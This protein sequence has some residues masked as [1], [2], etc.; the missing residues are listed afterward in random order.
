MIELSV[1][2]PT[3][4]DW[5]RLQLCLAPLMES[6]STVAGREIIVVDNAPLHDPPAVITG[7]KGV[8]IIHEPRP[9]SYSARNS[10]ARVATGRYLA[11]T[12]SDCIPASDWMEQGIAYFQK[13]GADLLGGRVNL[14]R[15]NGGKEWAYIYEQ[16]MAFRQAVNVPR[17][18]SVTANLMV[19]KDV[20]DRLG[21]FDEEM[22]SGGDFEFCQRA[23]ENGYTLVYADSVMVK[24]P[25]RRDLRSIFKKQKRFAAW[26]FLNVKSRYGHSG[27]RII[28]SHLYNGIRGIF[29]RSSVPK[30]LGDKFLVFCISTGLYFYTFWL[31]SLI[32]LRLLDA[33]KIRE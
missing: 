31:Q 15:E 10:G 14:F 32:Q 7:M 13:T 12:D 18:H 17:G 19:R 1:V 30:S 29:R 27:F 23:V 20:F 8:T 4:N 28:G 33:K 21:G 6:N 2:I 5:E 11:F 9:G 26:G 22:N 16:H 25:A 3:F 24:H